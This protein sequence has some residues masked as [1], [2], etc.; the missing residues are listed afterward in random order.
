[1]DDLTNDEISDIA[2]QEKQ[3]K[4]LTNVIDELLNLINR[5]YCMFQQLSGKQIGKMIAEMLV[6]IAVL[7]LA[8][9]PFNWLAHSLSSIFAQSSW[10]HPIVN[11]IYF[12]FDI[13]HLLLSLIIFFY[14][15]NMRYLSEFEK[16]SFAEGIIEEETPS[17]NEAQ[18]MKKQVKMGKIVQKKKKRSVSDPID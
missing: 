7:A 5:S 18:T 10:A 12:V 2:I 3:Q 1:M 11:A 13:A 14:I 16:G 8:K 6:L 17:E 15:Y 9:I 4:N